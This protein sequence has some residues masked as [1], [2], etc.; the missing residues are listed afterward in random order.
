MA[1]VFGVFLRLGLTSFGGP[2][3]HLGYFRDEFVT[4]RKWLDEATFA[5]IVA[6]CSVLPGPTSSQVGMIVGLQRAG[7]LGMLLAWVGFTAP[8]AILLTL[9]AIAVKAGG[10]AP[11]LWLAGLLAGL[12]A[13]A[14][15]VIA[16]AVL[17]L[18]RALCTGRATQTI[19]LG[20]AILAIS[21]AA[22]PGF[23]WL[24]I[25]LG[26][27]VGYTLLRA[28]D[29]TI[30]HAPLAIHIRPAIAAAAIVL[31]IAG[32]VFVSLESARSAS[33]TLL[34]TLFRAGSL[35]FGGGHVVLPLLQAL[36]G[37]GLISGRDFFAGYGAAQAIPGPLTTFAAF[38]GYDNLSPLHGAWGALV[39]TIVIFIPSA[40][41]IV[42]LIPFWERLRLLPGAGRA[43]RGANASVVGLLGAVL[44]SPILTS[45]SA[46][47]MRVGLALIAFALLAVWKFPPWI[48]VG[49]AGVLGI[50]VAVSGGTI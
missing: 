16:Q 33:A 29:D 41:L 22:I 32:A 44:Y 6:F 36:V 31:F 15:A 37:E 18:A 8:S 26:A 5:G 7:G 10:A 45:L 12:T 47:P 48:A 46:A 2:I 30:P 39:A 23:Q 38:L 13:A 3:A 34:A 19:A 42:G 50:I 1:D 17:G 11:P 21:T 27:V 4:R 43:L 20:A 35:V 24:P 28:N 9:F 14:A 49:A 25:A 40:L